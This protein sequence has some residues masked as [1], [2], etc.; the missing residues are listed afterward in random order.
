M[1]STSPILKSLSPPGAP[2]S[3]TATPGDEE[4][5]LRWTPAPRNGS[6]ILYYEYA[7]QLKTSSEDLS[8]ETAPGPNN[9]NQDARTVTVSDLDNDET[10]TFSV[11]AYNANGHGPSISKDATPVSSN[12]VPTVTGPEDLAITLPEN[13]T[14]TI[15][16]FTGTDPDGDNLE[17]S[18][19]GT[20]AA[21]FQLGQT[22]PAKASERILQL[23]RVPDF[24]TKSSYAVSVV[25]TD[26]GGLLD[27]EAVT[28]TI[29]DVNE[30]PSVSGPA[31][32]ETQENT[33][34]LEVG[35]YT[36]SDPEDDTLTWDLDGDQKGYFSLSGTGA[37]RSLSFKESPDH[38]ERE[39][40]A[41]SVTVSD[42]GG[43]QDLVEV[44]VT[45]T[46]VNEPPTITSGPT[47]PSVPEEAGKKVGTYTASDPDAGDEL[48][49]SLAGDDASHFERKALTPPQAGKQELH[50]QYIP[51]HES[52]SSYSVE[53]VVEDP[54]G[55][56]DTVAVSVSVT[57][58]D[59]PGFVTLTPSSP[60]VGQTVVAKLID[61]DG[62]VREL[63]WN[64][65]LVGG[66]Q[67]QQYSVRTERLKV[68]P[69][70]VGRRLAVLVGYADNHGSG[71]DAADTTEVVR[72][73]TPS[74][75]GSLTASGGDRSVTLT[76]TAADGNG[77][78]ILSYEYKQSSSET[79]HS[80]TG[81]TPRSR[82]ITHLADGTRLSNGPEYSF[83][84][85]AR[86]SEGAGPSKTATATP[87]P[88]PNRPPTL[89]CPATASIAENGS[90]PWV[91][92]PCTASDPDN[93]VQDLDWD[94]SGTHKS[95][96]KI[97]GTG[98]R[99]SLELTRQPNHEARDSYAPVKITVTDPG[100]LKAEQTVTV[101]VDDVNEAPS[102]SGLSLVSVGER[103]KRV[104][105]YTA[106]DP[107]DGQ[108]LTW[109]ETSSHFELKDLNP[110]DPLKRDLYFTITTD[111]NATRSYSVDVTVT[112]S[113]TPRLSATQS[114]TVNVT[115]RD[116][117]PTMWITPSSP[118]VG[119]T[120]TA[121][122]TDTDG[123]VTDTTWSWDRIGV[124]AAGG[125]AGQSQLSQ[126]YSSRKVVAGD[127][128]SKLKATV[129]YTDNHGSGK[130]ASATTG[131]V[132]PDKPGAVGSLTASGGDKRVTL[133]WTAA[134][135]NGATITA[136][137]YRQGSSGSWL[138]AGHGAARSKTIGSLTNGTA[139]T[140]SLRAYNSVGA[141][142][143]KSAS[144]TPATVPGAPPDF[145]AARGDG[146]TTL[147]WGAAAGNG[148]TI[149]KY[150]Y[151]RKTSSATTWG[152]WT[153]AGGKSARSKKV[154]GLTNGTTY[155]FQLRAV[156]G[157]G[158]GATSSASATPAGLPG[159]PPNLTTDR[160]EVDAV[161]IYWDAADAN[162]SAITKYQYRRRAGRTG[163]WRGWFSVPSSSRSRKVTGLRP[164][165]R[166]T[167]ELRAVNGVG[168][169]PVSSVVSQP[170]GI[171]GVSGQSEVEP[172]PG[173]NIGDNEPEPDTPMEDPTVAA[174]AKPVA[175]GG[176]AA[177]LTT[178]PNPFNASTTL[179]YHLAEDGPVTLTLFNV[180]GQVV[181]VLADEVR[182]AGF[183]ETVWD[184]TREA[185]GVYFYRLTMRGRDQVGKVVLIR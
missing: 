169:G 174:S 37:S 32:F 175:A 48:T 63:R 123:G 68:W 113:G 102:V 83:D 183:H 155:N 135:T 178:Y 177:V 161:A 53:V 109:S 42:P 148:S 171:G 82:K 167:W 114:V 137:R 176:P 58:V 34:A 3:L 15:A 95:S 71:K 158:D 150:E 143:A 59:E 160:P 133:S 13:G 98:G 125:V 21:F 76:W 166:Y 25:V 115:D 27:S 74:A 117:T 49:W 112:D 87:E 17:W 66:I 107:D 50:F 89:T 128:G 129:S 64:W 122:L 57:D 84:V 132:R 136:Y 154:T 54:G 44:A 159:A 118:R 30:A 10:Y 1:A 9:Q 46:D 85:R 108:T 18:V 126:R 165:V 55:L 7:Y 52:R 92:A 99:R 61:T 60:R 51:D 14:R 179:R 8:W 19:L 77:A 79:W 184:G 35:T 65:K 12:R 4:V 29:T 67:G 16:T 41:V 31:T 90:A 131:T 96:F 11:R 56:S 2:G 181:A 138:P 93:D 180:A 88:P 116:N 168:H 144:A 130:S 120:V 140:F 43:L 185:S 23:K 149:T 124:V 139:Y 147:T 164:L 172:A 141:G 105:T 110:A 134:P 106:S 163:N 70:D 86:N 97:T 6:S 101:T 104:G 111:Y 157:V 170:R 142:P 81:S 152:S 162:G 173:D 153:H 69:G 20:D 45:V 75:V 26:P 5:A 127:V 182:P 73:N 103:L 24:E 100:G 22:L 38:E 146:E 40:Y 39:T 119:E 121:T 91:V 78:P 156:N 47:S 80:L 28:V 33:T 36:A 151:R 145:H 94:H 62:G 72:A